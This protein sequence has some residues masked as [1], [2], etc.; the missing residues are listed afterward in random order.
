MG[1][2]LIF[3]ALVILFSGDDG[4]SPLPIAEKLNES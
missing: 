3:C 2:F 4:S 1:K